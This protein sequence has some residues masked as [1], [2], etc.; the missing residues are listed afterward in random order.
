MLLRRLICCTSVAS[1]KGP[2]SILLIAN[3]LQ[4]LIL[5]W[6]HYR[7]LVSLCKCLG[8]YGGAVRPDSGADGHEETG[9]KLAESRQPED[10][11]RTQTSQLSQACIVLVFA[12]FRSGLGRSVQ[13]W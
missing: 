10:T 6:K 13:C 11:V 3:A 1:T 5:W 12:S 9:E 8:D 4:V 7:P 2:L